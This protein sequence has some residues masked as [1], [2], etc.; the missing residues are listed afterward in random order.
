MSIPRRRIAGAALVSLGIGLAGASLGSQPAD[1]ATAVASGWWDRNQGI[2]LTAPAPP[3]EGALRV[4][5]DPGGT[6]AV[7]AV[8]YQ[9]D[10]DETLPTLE[11][12]VTGSPADDTTALLACITT[13]AWEPAA[14]GPF[15]DAPET[16]CDNGSVA[17]QVSSDG[18]VVSFGLAPLVRGGVLDV[19]IVPVAADDPVAGTFSVDFAA[20]VDDDVSTVRQAPPPSTA[21]PA[22]AA[23]TTAPP[24]TRAPLAQTTPATVAAPPPPAPTTAPPTTTFVSPT[25]GG[26]VAAPVPTQPAPVPQEVA[27]AP[28]GDTDDGPGRIGALVIAAAAIAGGVWLW[29]GRT[30]ETGPEIGGLGKFAKPRTGPVADVS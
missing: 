23:A 13:T 10:A 25:I 2:T 4:A 14:G 24:T 5:S 30:T 3:P 8:R 15:A 20:P 9:L 16:D 11:L 27:T 29:N 1:A 6:S 26:A 17:G 19:A 28:V 18:T 12:R 22:T 21:P 7:A